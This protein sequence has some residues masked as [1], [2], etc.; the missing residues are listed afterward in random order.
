MGGRLVKPSGM[1]SESFI[2]WAL[3]E[4]RTLDERYTTELLVAQA[5]DWWNSRH[6]IYNHEP[7]EVRMERSRQRALNPA[8]E[9]QYSEDSVRKAAEELPRISMWLNTGGL[10]DRPI[11]DLQAFRFLPILDQLWVCGEIADLSPLAEIPRL[12]ILHLT[13]T[14]CED[15]TPLA[16]C[17]QLRELHLTH[18]RPYFKSP[19]MWPEFAGLDKLDQ[20]ENLLLEGNLLAFPHGIT[21][22]KVRTGVL[23]CQPLDARSVRDLPQL[24]ACEILTLAGVEKLDG[25][26]AFPH[27]RNLTLETNVRDFAPLAALNHLTTF[28]C[29]AFEPLDI[30]PLARL[31]SLHYAVFDSRFQFATSPARLRDFAPLGK[32][33][34]LRELIVEN[35]P[36]VALEV[37]AINATLQAWNDVLLAPS[38]RPLPKLRLIVA[39]GEKFPQ[40]PDIQLDPEDCGLADDGMRQCEGRWVSRFVAGNVSTKLGCADWGTAEADGKMRRVSVTIEAF[41]VVE[42]LPQIVEAVRESLAALRPD[43]L[44]VVHI[45]LKEPKLQ[46]TDAQKQLL[47][48]FQTEQDEAEYERRQREQAEYLERLHEYE[49]KKQLGE[50]IKPEEFAPGEQEPLPPPP[51]EREPEEDEDDGDDNSGTGGVKVKEKPDPPPDPWDDEHP[52]A[53]NYRLWAH[54]TLDALW[55]Y[56]HHRDLAVYL[57]GREPDEEIPDEKKPE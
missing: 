4:A 22:P 33:P 37:A 36:P 18:W 50:P 45:W 27:L 9:P 46:M 14:L 23:R 17:S 56:P 51:W 41:A 1:D 38:P 13:S 29:R 53:D 55:V 31:P 57:M 3:D 21:W 47:A 49:L 48:Q 52:L 7:L 15:Y 11:R 43:Y 40:H 44:A 26:E 34:K 42:K 6:K 10:N 24:P 2:H 30:S 32:A 39:P 8:Y 25:I 16:R 20:L 12:R 54:L 19:P 35:C 28:I 5:V